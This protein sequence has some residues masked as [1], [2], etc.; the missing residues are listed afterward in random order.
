AA[1]Q[2]GTQ[3]SANQ[4]FLVGA[5]G[6]DARTLPPPPPQG[7][8]S[9][10]AW[11]GSGD[12][13]IYAM[14]ESIVIGG[15]RGGSSSIIRQEPSSKCWQAIMSVASWVADRAVA[16]PG[17]LVLGTVAVRE[18]LLELTLSR[19]TFT[20][21]GRWLTR[22]N[23]IDR[24]PVYSPNGEGVLFSSNRNGNLDLWEVSRKTGAIRRLTDDTAEDWDPGFNHDGTKILW[25]SNRSGH[26]EIW[27]SESDGTGARKLTDD[28][29]D[30]ENPVATPDG[31][32][33]V[34]SSSNPARA[35]LWKIHPDGTGAVRIAAGNM[36]VPKV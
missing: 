25:S 18:N 6:R 10:L 8:L 5:D 23:S 34:Y 16:G 17:R 3:N 15:S 22:G 27:I 36:R 32:W 4:L 26:F 14:A 21:T 29:L 30:A 12:A 2:A 28:G 1:V 35:G 7:Q 9:S 13:V 31:E 24:Q 20:S 11:S 19:D 33:I